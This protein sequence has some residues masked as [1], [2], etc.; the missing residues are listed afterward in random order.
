M[1]SMAHIG[2]R[3]NENVSAH[4][5]YAM[6]HTNADHGY[7]SN[8]H[9]V[10]ETAAIGMKQTMDDAR[11]AVSEVT[12]AATSIPETSF[13]VMDSMDQV[14]NGTTGAR[15]ATDMKEVLK[16]ESRQV[17]KEAASKEPTAK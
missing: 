16:E 7:A 15:A 10:M 13:K 12:N 4:S 3:T 11:Q 17:E 2:P 1:D 9:N 6:G 5:A 14:M 8:P